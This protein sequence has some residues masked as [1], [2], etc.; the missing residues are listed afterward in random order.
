MIFNYAAQLAIASKL[1]TVTLLRLASNRLRHEL[2]QGEAGEDE[3]G[4]LDAIADYQTL[5]LNK[6]A[7][8]RRVLRPRDR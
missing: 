2:T 1:P 6:P 5:K 8:Q 3:Q 4:I 7:L